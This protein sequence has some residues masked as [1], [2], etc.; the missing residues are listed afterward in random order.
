[1]Q[2]LMYQQKLLK[3]Q[4][5]LDKSFNTLLY[6]YESLD[7]YLKMKICNKFKYKGAYYFL[8]DVEKVAVYKRY[9]ETL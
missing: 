6:E 5:D 8:K 3:Q 9:L 2:N 1:M 7:L 4:R